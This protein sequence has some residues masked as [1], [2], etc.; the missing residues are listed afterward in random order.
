MTLRNTDFQVVEYRENAGGSCN[1]GIYVVRCP[2]GDL[3]IEK[4]ASL[5]P[6]AVSNVR[7]E[8]R[9]LERCKHEYI[10]SLFAADLSPINVNPFFGCLFTQYCEM[11]SLEGNIKRARQR[12]EPIPEIFLWRLLWQMG[13]ALCYLATGVDVERMARNGEVV[14]PAHNWDPIIHCDIKPSNIF[15]TRARP[16][17]EYPTCVLGDFGH[18]LCRSDQTNVQFERAFTRLGTPAFRCPEFSTSII[19][20]GR[21]DVYAL[22][23]VLHCTAGL[24]EVPNEFVQLG[25]FIYPM[26]TISNQLKMI[27]QKT[28]EF[29]PWRRPSPERLPAMIYA[30]RREVEQL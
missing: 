19:F 30:A 18:A 6:W 15:L 1:G 13:L 16:G 22:G 23:L 12:N 11:G 2:R 27:T 24:L 5:D 10:I 4:R 25:M 29:N 7:T 3:Y 20:D 26:M 9:I 14:S 8:M 28:L 17:D 21:R